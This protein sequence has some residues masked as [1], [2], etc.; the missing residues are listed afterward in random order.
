MIKKVLLNRKTQQADEKEDS[1]CVPHK[2][3]SK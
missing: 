3:I 2:Q 1:D